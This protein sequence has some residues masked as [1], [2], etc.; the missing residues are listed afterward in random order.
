MSE[1]FSKWQH[2][3]LNIRKP[4]W[5]EI[6]AWFHYVTGKGNDEIFQALE[7]DRN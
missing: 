3:L 7:K 1:H 2:I 4:L 5:Y 6:L